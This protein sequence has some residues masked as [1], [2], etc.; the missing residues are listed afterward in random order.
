[1]KCFVFIESETGL[2][3]QMIIR[4]IVV[5]ENWVGNQGMVVRKWPEQKK[6]GVKMTTGKYRLF[7][8]GDVSV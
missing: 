1:M 2:T 8:E 7:E 5:D 6:M 4:L 3:V